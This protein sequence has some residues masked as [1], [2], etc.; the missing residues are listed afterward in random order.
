MIN[1]FKLIFSY[2][3]HFHILWECESYLSILLQLVFSNIVWQRNGNANLFP[4]CWD[5]SPSFNL[6]LYRHKI[7]V[8]TQCL[9]VVGV[10]F[11]HILPLTAVGLAS[12]PYM[13]V[14][15]MTPQGK[16][17]YHPQWRGG[18]LPY[19]FWVWVDIQASFMVCSNIVRGTH[20]PP[21]RIK[22][23][24]SFLA[25]L[26]QYWKEHWSASLYTHKG[27][28]IDSPLYLWLHRWV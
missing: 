13:T 15:V 28:I 5:W 4:L 19:N 26:T 2:Y 18:Y 3:G 12:L 23:L 24:A 21:V 9:M 10:L 22:V 1:D 8:G 25:A 20:Y 7:G 14:R 27:G 16:L 6:C 17:W 11:P